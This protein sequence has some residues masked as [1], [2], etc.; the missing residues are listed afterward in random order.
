MID[1]RITAYRDAASAMAEGNFDVQLPLE[2]GVDEI[3]QLGQALRTLGDR[4]EEKFLELA[5][6]ARVTE[7]ANAGLLLD[8][9][10]DDVYESFRPLIPYDRIGFSLIDDDKATVWAR[11]ARSEAEEMRITKGFSAPLEGSSL[12]RIIDTGEPRI[13]NDLPGY[14]ADHPCSES[15]Q[16]IVEEGMHSSLTCPL[17][18]LGKPIGFMFFSSMRPGTYRN[19]HVELFLQIARQLSLIVE[20]SRI[21][22]ELLDLNELKDR[23]LGMAAHDLRNPLNAVQGYVYLLESGHFG[24]VTEKQKEVLGRVMT[25]SLG[26]LKLIEDLLDVNVIESGHLTLEIR[27]VD[28]VPHLEEAVQAANLLAADKSISVE[29]EVD[30]SLPRVLAD[31]KRISQV[32]GN[33]LSNA[34]KYSHPDTRVTLRASERDGVVDVSVIDQGQGIPAEEMETL[35]TDFGRTSVRPTG[36]ES[37]T[38]LGLAIV[39][40]IVEA[41]GGAVFVRSEVGRG[42]TF[43]FTLPLAD[44]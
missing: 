18:A 35:F 40:R 24:E 13:L 12:Q 44:A 37:S 10:L 19:V 23:F 9:V 16:L 31:P 8:E 27:P 20:K 33:L 4:L 43:S 11:W 6:L 30:G 14:L 39:K 26:M 21:Y 1:S 34:V 2:P 28:P 32:L 29:L 42:S 22:Q 15:T 17:I 5:E 3:G 7:R 36:E 25:Q 41:H 38:G